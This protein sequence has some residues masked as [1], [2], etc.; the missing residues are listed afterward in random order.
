MK[1]SSERDL[2]TRDIRAYARSTQLRLVVGFFIVLLVVGNGLIWFFYGDGAARFALI[3]TLV[4]L[5]PAA[6]IAGGLWIMEKLLRSAEVEQIVTED[7]DGKRAD[8]SNQNS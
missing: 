8:L 4:A 7:R 1:M 5:I 6:L 2:R 3:C